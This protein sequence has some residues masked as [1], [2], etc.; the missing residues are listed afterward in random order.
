MQFSSKKNIDKKQKIE[1][2]LYVVSSPIGNLQDITLRAIYILKNSELI[3][4]EDT[5]TS[6]KLLKKFNIN[7]KM[8]SYHKFN[9]KKRSGKIIQLIKNNKIVSLI[10]DAGTPVISDPGMILINECIKNNIVLHP[11]PGPSAV[12]SALSIS[13]F[14]EKFLFYG[15][16][17]NSESQIKNEIKNLCDFPYSI[18]FFVSSNKIN[19][20]IKIFKMF[21]SERKIMIAKEMTKI[22]ESFIRNDVNSLDV[23]K[24]NL[25]GELTVVI[26][27]KLN[28]KKKSLNQLAES[29]KNEIKLMLKKYSNKDVSNFISKREKI[30][31]KIIYD[32]CISL[33]K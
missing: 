32:Y 8:I 1:Q 18:I 16:L 6:I 4:C 12:T 14:N 24:Y 9:E 2:G 13:G 22:Y 23:S 25:K 5:R 17:P 31:K 15:F 3:L 29:V 10:S 27:N 7:T 19:K 30:S 28:V 26:S 33:K 21:F 20:V 11:I